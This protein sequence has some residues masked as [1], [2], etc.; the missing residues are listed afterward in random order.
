[1]PC[2]TLRKVNSL[3]ECLKKELQPYL[4]K[5]NKHIIE[6]I[7]FINLFFSVD[8]FDLHRVQ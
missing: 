7:V 2:L 5:I 8:Y 3:S 4:M 6:I 1:M